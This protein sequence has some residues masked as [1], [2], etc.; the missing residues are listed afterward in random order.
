MRRQSFTSLDPDDDDVDLE[1]DLHG[2]TTLE[3]KI[4]LDEAFES[5]SYTHIRII[6][7]KGTKSQF[8]AVLPSFVQNYLTDQKKRFHFASPEH[9]GEGALDVY[10]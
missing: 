9:G 1:L 2:C 4:M 8:G 6:V 3:A 10:L 5:S 7:G